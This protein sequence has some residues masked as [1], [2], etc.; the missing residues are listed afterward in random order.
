MTD[1]TMGGHDWA[2]VLAAGEGTRLA[3]LTQRGGRAIPKQFW[4][5]DG[6]RT[7]LGQTLDRAS[8]LVPRERIVVVVAAQ[9]A[10][11]WRDE[12]AE[13]PA[14]NILVQPEN[15]GT[16]AGI[17]L[18]LLAIAE[19]DPE[20][21][22][23]VLPSDHHVDREDVLARAMGRALEVAAEMTSSVVMLGIS[24]DSADPDL[25]WIAPSRD[26]MRHAGGTTTWT[27]DAFVEKPDAGTARDLLA[28]R[29]LW[30]SFLLAAT[31]GALLGMYARRAPK[32]LRSLHAALHAG[33][34]S[35]Q[36]AYEHLPAID[37]SRSLIQGSEEWLRL[38]P[39]PS[40]GWSDLGTPER[41]A[42]TLSRRTSGR[43]D[44]I[45]RLAAWASPL[46]LA[47]A[48]RAVPAEA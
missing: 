44:A 21:R 30:N 22:L 32:L 14:E 47:S 31:V 10:A 36:E 42:S 33:E 35:L 1:R 12:L 13:I 43:Q 46:I 3:S 24:P 8:R 17:L 34:S 16:A 20:G 2:L 38:L 4:S 23:L 29:G 41:V 40:C 11:W 48:F 27:I 6:G 15:R 37:F 9:H 39:V 26:S 25:G 28:R 45:E 18:P 7:L 5:L 19:R